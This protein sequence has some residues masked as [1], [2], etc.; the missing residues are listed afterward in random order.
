MAVK[1][2]RDL[3]R[4]KDASVFSRFASSRYPAV[5]TDGT[6]NLLSGEDVMCLL[7]DNKQKR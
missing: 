4:F 6:Q 3:R 1:R 5:Y 2:K 7:R